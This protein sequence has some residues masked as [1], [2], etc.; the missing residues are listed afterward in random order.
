MR[1]AAYNCAVKSPLF[2]LGLLGALGL[3]S[4]CN[5]LGGR[6]VTAIVRL[7]P[8][9][10]GAAPSAAGEM[11]TLEVLGRRLKALGAGPLD[12]TRLPGEPA[13]FEL[14][15]RG[16]LPVESLKDPLS[17]HRLEFRM[18]F[19][20]R[21]WPDETAARADLGPVLP[22]D[23]L[24]LPDAG[25]F[26]GTA[27]AYLVSTTVELTGCDVQ[28]ASVVQLEPAGRSVNL[29]LTEPAGQAMRALSRA[30][31]GRRL[32]ILYDNQVVMAATIQTEMGADLQINS[33]S[34]VEED[35][36][37]VRNLNAGCT[38]LRP[39]VESIN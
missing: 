34:T 21:D 22:A 18:L 17:D 30:N 23:T 14:K 19:D 4:G 1:G 37:L 24:L 6:Q 15:F 27:H 20:N 32:A 31:I 38:P 29:K 8:A 28:S 33:A 12:S 7:E 35:E 3:L 2:V 26:T 16:A 39:V 9:A 13:R 36:R 25:L 5:R 11:K 10:A